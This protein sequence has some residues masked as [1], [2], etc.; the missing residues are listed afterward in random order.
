MTSLE[1]N[2]RVKMPAYFLV[3][4]RFIRKTVVIA[5]KDLTSNS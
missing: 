4:P 1:N 3:K 5:L 2:L